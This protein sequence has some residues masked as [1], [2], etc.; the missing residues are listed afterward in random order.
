MLD[1][2]IEAEIASLAACYGVPQ[3]TSVALRGAP[4]R[5]LNATDRIGEVCMVVRR[6]SGTFLAASKTYYP[7]GIF[8]LLTG[9]INHGEAIIDALLRETAEET[10]L[11]VAVRRFLAV[12]AYQLIEDA[13]PAPAM[14][15]HTF[16][17]FAFL[18]DEQGGTLGTQDPAEQ[19]GAF[20]EVALDELPALAERLAHVPDGFHPEIHG[21]WQDWGRFRAVV[22]RVVHA[23]LSDGDQPAGG[24]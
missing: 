22:H 8:R 4:F 15:T 11:D 19:L 6:P 21:S 5:P 10:G 13:N 18:L 24:V 7:P 9:G 14:A 3:H 20:Y 23:A 16:V 17:T 1:P 12:I 2:A